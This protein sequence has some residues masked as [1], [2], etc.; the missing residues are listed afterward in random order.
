MVYVSVC[1]L[2]AHRLCKCLITKFNMVA[3]HHFGVVGGRGTTHEGPFMAAIPF[4]PTIIMV[5]KF[6]E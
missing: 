6:S 5:I 2:R 3:F 1:G 4:Q